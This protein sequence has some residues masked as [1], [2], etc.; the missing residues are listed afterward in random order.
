[1]A[2]TNVN[3]SGVEL[4]IQNGLCKL[5]SAMLENSPPA[6]TEDL[7]SV[8]QISMATQSIRSGKIQYFYLNTYIIYFLDFHGNPIN[9]TYSVLCPQKCVEVLPA[10][11][12]GKD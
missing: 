8:S 2:T 7:G 6:S 4:R 5:R 11:G 9:N 10:S 12:H 1:M 3:Q